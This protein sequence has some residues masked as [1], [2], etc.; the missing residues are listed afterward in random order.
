MSQQNS[1]STND[2]STTTT[3][4][5]TTKANSNSQRNVPDWAV[6]VLKYGTDFGTKLVTYQNYRSNAAVVDNAVG[7][8][9]SP[10]LSTEQKLS[11][12]VD[13][14]RKNATLISDQCTL[15]KCGV[16]VQNL[17]EVAKTMTS[18][19]VDKL[20]KDVLN[21][22]ADVKKSMADNFILTSAVVSAGIVVLEMV[23]LYNTWKEIKAAKN[24]HENEIDFAS[25][26]QKIEEFKSLCERLNETI[27]TRQVN[28]LV[29]QSN[30][31]NNKYNEI[32]RMINKL[33]FKIDGVIQR[34][35]LVAD[36]QFASGMSNGVMAVGN[37]IQ[38][39]S[40]FDSLSNPVKIASTVIIGLFGALIVGNG[41]LYTLTQKRLNE[42][43]ADFRQLKQYETQ[44]ENLNFGIQQV[45]EE[46][47][48]RVE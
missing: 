24:L 29:L 3:T 12:F 42:L 2:Q 33:Q 22:L 32:F 34:L 16:N 44:L 4:T 40:V 11:S 17:P 13:F 18:E 21:S 48:D 8:I 15:P 26:E 35:D 10:N 28:R 45:L 6:P 1:E 23:K 36:G 30:R 41:I 31:L 5:T 38:L 25:I 14:Q 19:G 47:E 27:N 46:Q 37:I 43:R 7:I 39:L 20:Q 9:S